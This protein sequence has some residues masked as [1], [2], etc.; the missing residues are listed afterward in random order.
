MPKKKILFII[1]PKSGIGKHKLLENYVEKILDKNRFEYDISYT[2]FA[3]HG[4]EL[5]KDA[6]DKAYDIVVASGGDGSI[7]E[8]AK[9]IIGSETLLGIIPVGSGNGLAHHLQIPVNP[10]QAIEVINKT[11]T[12]NIDTA[13]INEKL[14]VSIAGVGFDALVAKKFTKVKRRGFLSYFKIIAKEYPKYKAQNYDINIDGKQL[15]RKALFISFAN[16][17][18]FGYNTSIAPKAKIDDGLI[19]VCIVKKIPIIELPFLAHLLYWKQIDKSKFIETIKGKEIE[20]RQEKK[21]T[22]NIDGEAIKLE[23]DILVKINPLS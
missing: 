5:A 19:D 2:K 22:V 17:D 13:F 3:G 9:G 18:Q 7:N 4:T 23:K 16:S 14:F 10:I 1:N 6:I 8:V 12:I 21:S 11:N 20:I 15:N